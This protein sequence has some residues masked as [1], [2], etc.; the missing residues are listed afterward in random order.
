MA[1]LPYERSP[2]YRMAVVDSALCIHIR[3]NIADRLLLTLAKYEP[4]ATSEE[5]TPGPGGAYAPAPNAKVT[6]HSQKTLEFTADMRPDQALAVANG[7][8]QALSNLT[9]KSKAQYGIPENIAPIPTVA[10][11]ILP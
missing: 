5:Y 7:I 6:S 9:A 10:V 8:L 1:Q 3:D 11:R 2:A 4:I